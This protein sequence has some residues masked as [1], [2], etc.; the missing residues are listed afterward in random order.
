MINPKLYF[1]YRHIVIIK[2][3]DNSDF[4]KRMTTR[5]RIKVVTSAER[6]RQ[7]ELAADE[8]PGGDA[9]QENV[10]DSATIFGKW[11]REWRQEKRKSSKIGGH[12]WDKRIS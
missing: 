4:T 2:G 1:I 3:A 8:V 9:T 10:Q 6:E 7:A 11:M 5:P 12:Q